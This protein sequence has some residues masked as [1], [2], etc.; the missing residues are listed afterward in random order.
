MQS[1]PL[2]HIRREPGPK[3]GLAHHTTYRTHILRLALSL[4]LILLT[5]AAVSSL[6]APRRTCPAPR[7]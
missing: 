6:L 3:A 7:R 4:W 2:A 5:F 1:T